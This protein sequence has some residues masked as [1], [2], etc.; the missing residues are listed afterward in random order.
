MV[1]RKPGLGR[2][3]VGDL[4]TGAFLGNVVGRPF[5]TM[6]FEPVLFRWPPLRLARVCCEH[7]SVVVVCPPVLRLSIGEEVCR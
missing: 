1:E 5:W 4:G 2:V 3:V 7:V 6:G